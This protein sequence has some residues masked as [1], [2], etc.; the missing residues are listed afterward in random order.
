MNYRLVT[1][2]YG[3]HKQVVE[4][5]GDRQQVLELGCASGY[6]SQL[7]AAKGCK[8][9]GIE[10]DPEAAL[11]A[12]QYCRSVIV[13][14]LNTLEA[15]PSPF[16]SF[17]VLLFADILEHLVDPV[18]VL[19]RFLPH[20]KTDGRVIISI[21]NIANWTIRW[22]LIRGRWDYT[23]TGLMDE[24]H[25]HFYTRRTARELLEMADLQI[26]HEDVTQGLYHLP[27]YRATVHRLL[28]H[29]HLQDRIAY[30]LAKMRP[31]LWALQFICVATRKPG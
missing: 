11:T 4:L 2:P 9:V 30:R 8:V 20:L 26:V 3:A 21:P 25:L 13:A 27:L 15:I 6:L 1:S 22:E 14:D 23:D 5:V 12:R 7:L 19:R 29:L 10:R 17:D 28:S 18:A 31:E 16:D 24:T